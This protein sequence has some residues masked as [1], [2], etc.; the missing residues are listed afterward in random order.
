[1]ELSRNPDPDPADRR[2]DREQARRQKEEA[3]S[4]VKEMEEA[5]QEFDLRDGY[6]LA[7][8]DDM[9][10]FAARRRYEE[11]TSRMREWLQRKKESEAKGER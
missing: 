1:V 4:L 11:E 9:E 8:S 10:R 2:Y 5:R 7:E 3:E 6:E